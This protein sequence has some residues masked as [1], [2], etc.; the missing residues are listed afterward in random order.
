MHALNR[1]GTANVLFS[2][3]WSEGSMFFALIFMYSQTYYGPNN[4]SCTL[5]R[6]SVYYNAY[7]NILLYFQVA[8]YCALVITIFIV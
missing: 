1:L 4:A 8:L 3:I 5:V 2:M 6:G 7:N